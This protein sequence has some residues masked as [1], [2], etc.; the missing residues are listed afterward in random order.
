MSSS[1]TLRR[2]TPDEV[3]AGLLV[4]RDVVDAELV[5]DVRA[6]LA[7][8]AGG[9]NIIEALVDSEILPLETVELVVDELERVF[10]TCPGCPGRFNVGSLARGARFKCKTCGQAVTVPAIPIT[11]DV[12]GRFGWADG[13]DN[14][15]DIDIDLPGSGDVGIEEGD[16]GDDID[17]DLDLPSAMPSATPAQPPAPKKRL[18]N[19]TSDEEAIDLAMAGG[20]GDGQLLDFTDV[21]VSQESID[22]TDPLGTPAKPK[23]RPKR[24]SPRRSSRRSSAATGD[25]DGD[26]DDDEFLLEEAPPKPKPALVMWMVWVVIPVALCALVMYYTAEIKTWMFGGPD[27]DTGGYYEGSDGGGRRSGGSS[28]YKPSIKAE[29]C[30]DWKALAATAEAAMAL[31]SEARTA[32]SAGDPS[33]AKAKFATA[34]EKFQEAYDLWDE[35]VDLYGEHCDHLKPQAEAWAEAHDP[36]DKEAAKLNCPG[37]RGART[38][39]PGGA[40]RPGD[41]RQPGHRTGHRAPAGRGRRQGR[42]RLS[43]QRRRRG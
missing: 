17:I 28:N 6:A 30:D 10:L 38:G 42:R 19:V 5:D 23:T 16:S 15:G 2:A 4:E 40:H 32:A 33:T 18:P 36:A 34:G 8:E 20:T 24:S 12:L 27:N 1:G 25:D 11:R 37:R 39:R 35:V 29:E 41:R 31:V 3:L 43:A 13:G 26:G 9:G 21:D 22:G 7:E 14:H